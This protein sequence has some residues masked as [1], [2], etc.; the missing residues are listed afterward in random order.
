ME[1]TMRNN[2]FE[3]IIGCVSELEHFK[4]RF[5]I[6]AVQLVFTIRQS[7]VTIGN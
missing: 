1:K 6:R 4:I 2:C 5:N 7:T 3:N